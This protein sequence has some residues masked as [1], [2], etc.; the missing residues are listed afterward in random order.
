MKEAEPI[1][2]RTCNKRTISSDPKFQR[3]CKVGLALV[4]ERLVEEKNQADDDNSQT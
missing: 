3:G 2:C 4:E 1:F